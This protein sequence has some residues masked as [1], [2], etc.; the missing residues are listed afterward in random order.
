ML[1]KRNYKNTDF[2]VHNYEANILG[3]NL[4]K[5]KKEIDS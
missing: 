5:V 2:D 4:K 3:M 1:R